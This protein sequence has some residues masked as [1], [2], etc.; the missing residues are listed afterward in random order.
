M[1]R[2]KVLLGGILAFAAI[3]AGFMLLMRGCLSQF[4]ERSARVPA[5]LFEK[6]GKSV[7]FTIIEFEKTTSY[8]RNGGMV[9]KTVN[10]TYWIQ[11][12]DGHSADFIASKKIKS[13]GSIKNFPVE[14]LGAAGD[15]AW[16]FMGEPMAFDAFTLTRVADIKILEE[17]NPVLKGRF[18]AERQY[19]IFNRTDQ[20]IYLTAKDGSKWKLDTR[21]LAATES[22]FNPDGS[23]FDAR[24]NE[25][26]TLI[27]Q[28]QV[29][30][31]SNYQQNNR[32]VV[33]LYRNKQITYNQYQ[34]MSKAFYSKRE[35]LDKLRD[36]LW[37]V[38]RELEE[39]KRTI[40]DKERQIES[41]QRAN[42]GFSQIKAN[43]D[44]A[45]GQWFGLYDKKEF[46]EL[47]ERVSDNRAYDQ[48]ARR[49]LL[50]GTYSFSRNKDAVIDKTNAKVNSSGYLDGGF[51][52]QKETGLPVRVGD[53]KALLI[54]HKDQVGRDGK[55][56]VTLAGAGYKGWTVNTGLSD[57]A[58]WIIRGNTLCVLGTDNKELS[59]GEVNLLEC[60][61]LDNGSIN[62]YDYFKKSTRN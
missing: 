20:N 35:L 34:E 32:Q 15:N 46:S 17:K 48:T 11:T 62:K 12:N 23:G 2:N 39:N 54:L 18:P 40:E 7:V 3:I 9:R 19:Y 53:K 6:N 38:K 4:D 21:T 25:L 24:I 30:Q 57:W 58:D 16:I 33:E 52:L 26:E 37:T 44:T 61:N 13:H 55:I 60:I 28:N 1:F 42:P 10:T 29:M 41:L 59:S 50:T 43:Q 27:K 14:M 49:D 8:S 22:E 31:D 5:L 51:L 56:Q 45:N 47:Y 36:S